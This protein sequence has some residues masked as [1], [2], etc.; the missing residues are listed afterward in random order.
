MFG[1]IFR[2]VATAIGGLSHQG[3]GFVARSVT[4]HFLP[5]LCWAAR[6]VEYAIA[7]AC[8]SGLPA[9]TSVATFFLKAFS[10][11]DLTRGIITPF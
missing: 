7:T 1:A 9:L 2:D 4:T 6:L 10:D 11:L 3:W 5:F 8:L